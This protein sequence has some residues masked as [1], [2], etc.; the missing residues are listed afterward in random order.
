MELKT[1]ERREIIEI[2]LI[3]IVA[4]MPDTIRTRIANRLQELG[5]RQQGHSPRSGMHCVAL[6]ELVRALP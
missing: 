2:M 5:E 1:E 4:D 3:A 6:A